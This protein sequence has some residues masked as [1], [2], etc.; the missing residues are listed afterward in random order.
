MYGKRILD[1]NQQYVD[2]TNYVVYS[3]GAIGQPVQNANVIFN[4]PIKYDFTLWYPR[5]LIEVEIPNSVNIYE[6]RNI[7]HG[8]PLIDLTT[9]LEKMEYGN[10][11]TASQFSGSLI[12]NNSTTMI[13]STYIKLKRPI[14]IIGLA[15]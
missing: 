11:F 12:L 10:S 5:F 8:T 3:N 1:K 7:I 9:V 2:Q 15:S 13:D 14:D 4:A 6:S